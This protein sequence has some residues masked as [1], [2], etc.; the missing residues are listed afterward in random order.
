[1]QR[2]VAS[3]SRDDKRRCFNHVLSV[4]NEVAAIQHLVSMLTATVIARTT[5]TQDDELLLAEILSGSIEADEKIRKL[6]EKIDDIDNDGKGEGAPNTDDKKPSGDIEKV[7]ENDKNDVKRCGGVEEDDKWKLQCAVIY[8][9]TRKRIVDINLNKLVIT[10]AFLSSRLTAD[11]M[12]NRR[13]DDNSVRSLSI[14]EECPFIPL[15]SENFKSEKSEV[16]G[17]MDVT[18]QP[19][20]AT[21]G[22]SRASHESQD[23]LSQTKSP[24]NPTPTL[25]ERDSLTLRAELDSYITQVNSRNLRL[26]INDSP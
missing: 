26:Q 2:S 20:G 14:S 24:M 8:R 22:A 21:A 1:M 3:T 17:A 5:T 11:N 12:S 18:N 6:Y 23:N 10:E 7:I 4:A 13:P 19:S 16:D 15:I 9:L 25:N